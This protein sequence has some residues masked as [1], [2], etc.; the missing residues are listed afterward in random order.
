MITDDESD[1]TSCDSSEEEVDVG[2]E[3][4]PAAI[5]FHFLRTGLCRKV[6]TWIWLQESFYRKKQERGGSYY[7]QHVQVPEEQLLQGPL[8]LVVHLQP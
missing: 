6:L 5:P 8:H 1:V 4:D 2:R 7:P 3:K